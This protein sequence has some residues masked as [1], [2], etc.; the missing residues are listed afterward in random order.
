MTNSKES[1]LS[2]LKRKRGNPQ[3]GVALPYSEVREII[4]GKFKTIEEYK[5]WV[6]IE[7]L[8]GR[9]EGFPL[10]PQPTYFRKNEWVSKNH[11]LSLTDEVVK[12]SPKLYPSAHTEQPSRSVGWRIIQ[13]IFGLS[14]HKQYA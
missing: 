14:K 11:F 10:H 13:Q 7:R 9:C 3:W 2:E 12:K 1:D 5:N 6:R 8:N 4:K